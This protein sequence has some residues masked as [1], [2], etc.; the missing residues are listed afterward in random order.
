[1]SAILKTISPDGLSETFYRDG[2]AYTYPTQL[3]YTKGNLEHALHRCK[4]MR[5]LAP[6][7]PR[8]GWLSGNW[9]QPVGPNE[10]DAAV[11][12]RLWWQRYRALRGAQPL[13]QVM[14]HRDQLWKIERN[15]PKGN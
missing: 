14:A 15:N 9:D 8:F 7:R 6:T 1:M 10:K 5:V 13:K 4:T 11:E 2:K 12:L 3:G